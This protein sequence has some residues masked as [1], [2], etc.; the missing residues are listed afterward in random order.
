MGIFGRRKPAEEPDATTS[1]RETKIYNYAPSWASP[2]F[3]IGVV[4]VALVLLAWWAMVYILEE[5]GVR[6]PSQALARG[7]LWALGIVVLLVGLSWFG[8]GLLDKYF[9]YRLEQRDK[10]LLLLEKR[11]EAMRYQT[12]MQQ[13]QAV[14]RRALSEDERRF[15]RLVEAVLF[16]AYDHVARHGEF[17]VSD[18]RPWA[19]R[20]A[21]A[22]KLTNETD[23]VGET[24][25]ARVGEWLRDPSRE[26]IIGAKGREQ[27]NLRRYPDLASAQR[28]LWHVPVVYGDRGESTFLIK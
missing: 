18:S 2:I 23:S 13:S 11:L 25:G 19:R 20:N 16:D 24:M 17:G 21:G 27:L 22:I 10:D 1:P 3:A 9:A 6:D 26:L 15:L 12:Q 4:V 28:V 7:L 14:D 5:A 8:A